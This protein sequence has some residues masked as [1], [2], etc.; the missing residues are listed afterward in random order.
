MGKREQ[1]SKKRTRRGDIESAIINCVAAAGVL[2]VTLLAPNA[3]KMLG[4]KEVLKWS[5]KKEGITEARKRLVSKG[6][7]KYENHRLEL[8]KK[9]EKKFRQLE[10][11]DFKNKKPKKWD[12]KWRIL[13]FDIPE[14][15]RALRDKVRLTL[16]A[17]GFTKLQ[18]SV[19]VYPYDCEDIIALMKVDFQIGRELLYLIVDNIE[20]DKWLEK[21]FGLNE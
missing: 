2:S 6:L 21:H 19:W 15:K 7:L 17:I 12:K 5:R 10:L 20:N 9:G 18:N 11:H 13:I 8:T 3:L 1:E 16:T 14:E 4:V